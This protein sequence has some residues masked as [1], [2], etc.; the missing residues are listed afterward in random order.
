MLCTPCVFPIIN[1]RSCIPVFC[2][3]FFLSLLMRQPLNASGVDPV[4]EPLTVVCKVVFPSSND[5]TNGFSQEWVSRVSAAV[6]FQCKVC[7]CVHNLVP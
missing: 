7:H 4:C 3:Y 1:S 5:E 2:R 6:H